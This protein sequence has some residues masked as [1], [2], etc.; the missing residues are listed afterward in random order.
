M[1]S[2]TSTRKRFKTISAVIILIVRQTGNITEYLLQ[3]RQNTG[4]SDGMWDFS[5]SGHVEKSES[6]IMAAVRETKEEINV[7]IKPE[8]LTFMG[9]FHII[10]SDG[11]PRL[12]GCFKTQKY[13]GTIRI[14]EPTKISELKWFRAD[15]LP[16]DIIPTRKIALEKSQTGAFYYEYNW[17]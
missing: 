8:D 2:K 16:Q 4:F 11:E 17:G 1:N 14:G 5:V 7:D 15:A 6:M 13:S 12:I 3:K 9:L 10:G